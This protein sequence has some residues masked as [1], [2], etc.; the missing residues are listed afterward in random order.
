M[1]CDHDLDA[2]YLYPSDAAILDIDDEGGTLRFTIAV[3]CPDCDQALKLTAPVED[4]EETT[5]EVPLDDPED[6]YD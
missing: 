6:P 4:V 1:S 5:M 3:P 2:E